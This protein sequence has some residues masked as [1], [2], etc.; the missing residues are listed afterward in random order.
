MNKDAFDEFWEWREKPPDSQLSI[1]SHLYHSVMSLPESEH[2]DRN[3]VNEAVRRDAEARQEGRTVWIY[4]DYDPARVLLLGDAGWA[5]VF[6]LAEVA[7]KW[8][9]KNDPEGGAWEYKIEGEPEG[10]ALPG[11]TRT[12]WLYAK[13]RGRNSRADPDTVKVF[14][15]SQG[16]EIWL[17]KNDPAG[18]LSEYAVLLSF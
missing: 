6:G 14:A 13:D 1:P 15:S 3:K 7:D 5:H 8:L 11:A 17:K 9:E 10:G 12:V 2:V 16:G 18:Q 4:F